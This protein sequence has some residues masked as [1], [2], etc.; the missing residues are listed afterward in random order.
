M[1]PGAAGI[2]ARTASQLGLNVQAQ[3]LRCQ[4]QGLKG[5]LAEGE[6]AKVAPFVKAF[7]AAG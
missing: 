4:V 2:L 7:V 5:P 3:T 6:L 1:N